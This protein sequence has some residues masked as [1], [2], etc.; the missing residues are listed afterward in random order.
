MASENGRYLGL[1]ID[2]GGVLTSDLFASFR[3]FCELEGLEPDAVRRRF[4]EDR[5]CRELLIALETGAVTRRSSSP[6]SRACSASAA[7]SLIDRLFAGSGPDHEMLDAVRRARAAG[8]RTGLVS[9]S[10]GTRRY[11]REVLAELFDGVVISGRGR[12]SASRRPRSTTSA[13]SGSGSSP[14]RACSSTTC[15]STFAQPPTSAWRPCFT[16]RRRRRSASSSACSASPFD[17]GARVAAAGL[18]ALAV[19]GCGAPSA[20]LVSLRAQAARVCQRAQARGAEIKPPSV[21]AQT[22]ASCAGASRYFA[23]NWPAC[24]R[25]ESRASVRHVLGRARLA[26]ARAHDPHRHGSRPR[27]GSRP[28][29]HDQGAPAKA[30]P[31]RGSG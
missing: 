8:V 4:R 12:E 2:W 3:A 21:P 25:C 24:A 10:W 7:P 31:G 11:P 22:A 30:G 29:D 26:R 17:E 23:P 19:V 9:N 13:R 5:D 6:G 14:T 28:I 27:P 15:R 18:V 1:L 16:A 20:T